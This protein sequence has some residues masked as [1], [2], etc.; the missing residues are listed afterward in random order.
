MSKSD[1]R[2]R[3]IGDKW[4]RKFDQCRLCESTEYKH[5][6]KGVCARCY[7]LM[8]RKEHSYQTTF[9]GSYDTNRR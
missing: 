6:S 8:N 7:Q 1:G 5:A 3:P 9:K 4:S 2:G